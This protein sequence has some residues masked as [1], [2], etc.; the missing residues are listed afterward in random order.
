MLLD[1]IQELLNKFRAGRASN[2]D[3]SVIGGWYEEAKKLLLLQSLKDHSGVKYILEV[4]QSEDV[5]ISQRLNSEY[6]KTLPDD[7]RDRLI[8]RRDLARKYINLFVDIDKKLEVLEEV[9]DKESNT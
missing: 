7:E 1:K 8:D 6:S 4:F 2:E 5:R 9:V 3:V